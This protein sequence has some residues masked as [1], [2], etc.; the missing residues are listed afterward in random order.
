MKKPSPECL[1]VWDLWPTGLSLRSI[2]KIL[3]IDKEMAHKHVRMGHNRGVLT[4][5]NRPGGRR[6][7]V[8]DDLPPEVIEWLVSITPSG[9]TV[10]QTI[11]AIIIDAYNEENPDA[12][13]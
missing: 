10:D 4:E 13:A 6:R 7:A 11:Q 1:R 5:T 9:A 3:G 8:T 12:L 2:G